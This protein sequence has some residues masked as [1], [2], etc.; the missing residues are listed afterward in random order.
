MTNYVIYYRVSTQRQ[1][2]SGLGLEAQAAAAATFTCDGAVLAEYRD[3]ESG[4]SDKNRPGL[5]D[6]M[7]HCRRDRATLVIAKLDRL[8]RNAHFLGGLMESEIEF[9]ACD[10]PFANKF[11]IRVLAA[12]AEHERKIISQR[13]KDAIAARNV[14]NAKAGIVPKKFNHSHPGKG[15]KPE[16]PTPAQIKLMGDLFTT[17]SNYTEIGEQ[18]NVL[19]ITTPRGKKWDSQNV[20]H[21]MVNTGISVNHAKG[22]RNY[23]PAKPETMALMK[24]LYYQGKSYRQIATGLND[25]GM[26]TPKGKPWCHR[27][28]IIQ[29]ERAGIPYTR[30]FRPNR[31]RPAPPETVALVVRLYTEGMTCGAIARHLKE[32]NVPTFKDAQ[33]HYRIVHEIIVQNV[34]TTIHLVAGKEHPTPCKTTSPTTVSP[35]NGNTRAALA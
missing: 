8:S 23:K 26:L 30:R 10:M 29:L 5:R 6:A 2:E 21:H 27:K 28:V 20:R 11:T 3:I 13:V 17:G 22:W 24:S 25:R 1:G 35:R 19:H 34:N 14:R 16:P 31:D 7:E 4:K 12:V 9:V 18:L 32:H 15:G 33:W